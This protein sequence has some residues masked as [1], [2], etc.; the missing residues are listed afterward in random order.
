MS[1]FWTEETRRLTPY[2]PGEQPSDGVSYIKI[3]TNESPYPPSPKVLAAIREACDERLRLYPNPDAL[4][5]RQAFAAANGLVADQVF[6]GNGSDEVLALAFKAFFGPK[7]GIT[8]PAVTYSCYPV[9][10][11][12][13]AVPFREIPLRS[14][15]SVPVE[16]FINAPGGIVLANPNAPT[17][18]ALP[19]SDIEAIVS[20]HPDDV[21]LIDEA[22]VDFGGESALP[23]ICRYPNLLVVRTMS[24]SGAL[25]G[26]RIGFAA[27]SPELIAGLNRVKNSFNSYTVDR[28]AMS[29]AV[30]AIEDQAYYR[31][32]AER[33]IRTRERVTGEL[34]RMGYHTTD[35]K[36]NF[37][38]ITHPERRAADIFSY[39]RRNGVLVRHFTRP[40]TESYLRVTIGTDAQMD[41]FLQLLKE[42]E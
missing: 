6:F 25:A 31:D 38:F 32:L 17:A 34:R 26:L 13:F 3:N 23:L 35:S 21:V 22:Y 18:I 27:G 29:A 41:R 1:K 19:L 30:A 16:A 5:A 4:P 39:L 15:F 11:D 8:I 40:E 20:A 2:V 42:M 12:L 14:D 37:I 10:C 28:L 36:A 7:R 33:I 24:K 9:Y